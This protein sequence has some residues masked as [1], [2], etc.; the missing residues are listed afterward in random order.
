MGFKHQSNINHTI[1]TDSNIFSAPW[2]IQSFDKLRDFYADFVS[3]FKIENK[4]WEE[5][6]AEFSH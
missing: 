6:H 3:H 5:N 1:A 4:V 2:V